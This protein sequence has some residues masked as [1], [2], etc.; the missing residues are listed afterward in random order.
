MM[1]A[2]LGHRMR[3]LLKIVD[4]DSPRHFGITSRP[5][6]Q[7]STADLLKTC[8]APQPRVSGRSRQWFRGGLW[9]INL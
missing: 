9:R 2:G 1:T 6:R 8:G 4:F 3:I 5:R 7:I